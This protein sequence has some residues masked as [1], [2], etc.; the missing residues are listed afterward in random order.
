MTVHRDRKTESRVVCEW[1]SVDFAVE[2]LMSFCVDNRTR[3]TSIL[4]G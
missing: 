4:A 2:C 1:S 3:K